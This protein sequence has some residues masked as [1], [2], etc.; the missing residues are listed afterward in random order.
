M[1]IYM[2]PMPRSASNIVQETAPASKSLEHSGDCCRRV[3]E[4]AKSTPGLMLSLSAHLV[5][6]KPLVLGLN[7]LELLLGARDPSPK[8]VHQLAELTRGGKTR[9]IDYLEAVR[10]LGIKPMRARQCW[11]LPANLTTTSLLTCTR[12][13]SAYPVKAVVSCASPS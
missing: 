12:A 6:P 13:L 8:L 1:A 11:S 9:P 2:Q 7:P 4:H 3:A 5:L 10:V